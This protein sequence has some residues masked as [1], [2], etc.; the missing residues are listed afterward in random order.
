MIRRGACHRVFL[1]LL[2]LLCVDLSHAQSGML[3]SLPGIDPRTAVLMTDGVLPLS[4]ASSSALLNELE[5][6]LRTALPG[7]DIVRGAQ[8]VTIALSDARLFA[9]DAVAL[10]TESVSV[11]QGLVA[12]LRSSPALLID[13]VG[14][15]DS[16]GAKAYNQQFSLRRASAVSDAMLAAGLPQQNVVTR[17]EGESQPRV[18]E[19][20]L[21]DRVRNRRVEIVITVLRAGLAGGAPGGSSGQ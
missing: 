18:P 19:T 9:P 7:T 6:K 17:G 21:A 13:V 2:A 11:L 15:T 20:T 3:T 12:L 4:D 10:N 8:A 16:F 1:G 5:A 14:H